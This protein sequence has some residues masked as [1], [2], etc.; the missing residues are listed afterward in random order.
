MSDFLLVFPFLAGVVA[1]VFDAIDTVIVFNSYS[2]L[3]LLV[4]IE[5]VHITLWGVFELIGS[6]NSKGS[7]E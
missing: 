2:V 4:S 3:D 7:E 5:Y 1:Q 6:D